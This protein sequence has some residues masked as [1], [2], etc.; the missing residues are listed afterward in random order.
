MGP[1]AE[2]KIRMFPSSPGV[3]LLSR[4]S[5]PNRLIVGLDCLRGYICE[6][7]EASAEEMK[8]QR[9]ETQCLRGGDGEARGLVE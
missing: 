1:T 9:Y 6:P 7:R 4:I 2:T 8:V 5:A 3:L